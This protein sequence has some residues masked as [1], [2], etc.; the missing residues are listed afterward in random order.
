[1]STGVPREKAVFCEAVEIT[2]LEQRRQFLDQACGADKV[3]RAQVE[4]LLALSQGS[5]DFF[6]ECAPA[7][8]AQPCDA[9]QVLSAG[10]ASLG[11]EAP[12]TR[13]IGRYKLLQRLGE[14]GYD[15]VYMAEQEQPIRRRVALKIIKLGMDTR[16]VIARFE[17]ER[18]ALALMD[19][20][21]IA[22]VLD[23]G[24][25]ETGRPYFVMELVYGVKITEYCDQNRVSMRERLELFIQVCNAVQHAHQKGIIHRDLKPSN[26]MVT[27]HDG[28]PVPKVIDFGIA[29][30]TEQR[31]T[32]KTLFTSYA[33]LMGTPAYMSPEQMELS[34]LNLD[35]RSDIYS[36][37]VL[38][39]ELLT[40]RTPFDTADLLKLGVEELRRTICERDPLSPSAKLQTL[41]KEE[42]T[43]TARRRHVEPPR[44]FS[45]L[46]GDLDWIVLKCLEKDRTRRYAT[47][48]AL[49][50]DLER[51]LHEEAVLARPPSQL[52]RLQKLVHRNRL[53]FA[54]I[55]AL[56]FALIAG[57]GT[58]T[59]LF[60][61][62]RAA[63]R[64]AEHG[65]ANEALLRQQAEA[66]AAI[67][68]A[69]VLLSENRFSAADQLLTRVNFPESGLGGAVV[70]RLLG[71]WA[72]AE[73]LWLRAAEYFRSLL[74]VDQM[75]TPD[76][77][78][79]DSTRCAVALIK[80][81]DEPGY[82]QFRRDIIERFGGTRYP[83]EAE[84]V[85]KNSL[86]LPPD[87]TIMATLAPLADLAIKAVPVGTPTA[88]EKPWPGAI[89]WRCVSPALWSYRQGDWA[90][91]V[92]W[93]RRC[94]AYGNGDPSRVATANAILAMSCFQL[95]QAQEGS[96][97]LSL[98]RNLAAGTGV[99]GQWFDWGLARILMN[100]AAVVQEDPPPPKKREALLRHTKAREIIAKAVL[101]VNKNK[102]AEADQL[103]GSLPVSGD[104]ATV[105]AAVFRALGDWAAVQ[106]NWSRAG[107]YYSALVR[108]DRFETPFLATLD[109][110]KNAM[111]LAE[112]DDQHAYENLACESIK[113][114]GN[115]A[116]SEI[117]E[118]IV[119]S[120]SLLPPS[121]SLAAALS[122]LAEKV[123]ESI[124]AAANPNHGALPWKCMSLALFE[125]HRGNYAEAV[126]WGNRC[127][128]FNQDTRKERVA[129]A[130]AI[131]AMSYHQLGQTEQARSAL[132]KS[133][134][135]VEERWKTPFTV[136]QDSRGWWYDWFLARFLERE[137][138]AVIEP[139]AP[140]A[141]R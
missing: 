18:Q 50:M 103:V 8:E 26:I 83:V 117:L 89:A 10:E 13:A 40:G 25:T 88:V 106:G 45:E 91:A 134:E 79:M 64:E 99:Q 35:T 71:D 19:H 12:E 73:G 1:M 31:L 109:Y 17:A 72:A 32:D 123:A 133:R 107:E 9:D 67:G 101:L 136:N 138:V 76:V 92:R 94:L 131:L 86:V 129:C 120:C 108:P 132:A 96:N 16:N 57:F 130:Q 66:R 42:L 39:Y 41:N 55:A 85:L 63:R 105:G 21:N 49:A 54:S 122:P 6:K 78:T 70:F 100:E 20:P 125:I 74:R 93:C 38:L 141:R 46:H 90:A 119:K 114:F 33:Q 87:K 3:L 5:G 113:Q 56:S 139:H 111:V 112:L 84:R 11:P 51:Y 104:A 127:L 77:A 98:S 62:E 7:L 43:K 97:A 47:A 4:G 36:L 82:D 81:C 61:R 30:A 37:G 68:Q 102:M 140:G 52:Y 115:T 110:N 27:M 14:G 24:A 28:V 23:A 95:G 65:R 53:V 59:W 118:R 34:G 44:L 60:F 80:A 126:N 137:A 69:A 135:L 58:S 128:S 15:V 29:K 124:R 48:N 2:D 121:A 22:R 75:E 116:N